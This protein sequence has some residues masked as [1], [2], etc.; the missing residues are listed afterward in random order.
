VTVRATNDAL[1]NLR[2]ED[3]KAHC[4]EHKLRDRLPLSP[5]DV[6]EFQ[7]GDVRFTAVNARMRRKIVDDKVLIAQ[8][9]TGDVP[10]PM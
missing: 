9:I 1:R 5:C 6:I 10:T 2:F 4:V 3:P 8:A 7:H